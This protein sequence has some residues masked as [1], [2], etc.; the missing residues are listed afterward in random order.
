MAARKKEGKEDHIKI[1][2]NIMMQIP[3]KSKIFYNR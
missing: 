1:V 3:Q 2:L